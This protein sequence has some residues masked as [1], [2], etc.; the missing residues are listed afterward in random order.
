MYMLML[1]DIATTAPICAILIFSAIMISVTF[2]LDVDEKIR[3]Q[4][5]TSEKE[6]EKEK[7]K[8]D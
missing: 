4:Q 5:V 8:V 3:S 2:I 6:K 1:Y 7:E